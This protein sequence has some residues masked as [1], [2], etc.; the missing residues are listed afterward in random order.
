MSKII[1][2]DD[3]PF[4]RGTSIIDTRGGVLLDHVGTVVVD[5]PTTGGRRIACIELAGRVNRSSAR[6]TVLYLLDAE[7]AARL[8]ADIVSLYGR[9][10]GEQQA[11]F[12]EAFDTHLAL[13]LTKPDPS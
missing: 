4:S 1:T 10:G 11:E 6:S 12:V 2:A 7:G 3:N 13:G 9:A 5:E 8:A